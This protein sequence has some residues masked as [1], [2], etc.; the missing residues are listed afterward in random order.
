MAHFLDI[1]PG[2][3]K[4]KEKVYKLSDFIFTAIATPMALMVTLVFW[5]IYLIDREL[6]FPKVIDLVMPP[7]INHS[8]HTMNT[9]LALGD[10][11]LVS[12]K[13]PS[14]TH[15]AGGLLCYLIPYAFCLFGTYWQTGIWLYPFLSKLTW[16]MRIVAA[17]LTFVGALLVFGLTKLVSYFMWGSYSAAPVSKKSQKHKRK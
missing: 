7:W 13:Y 14:W 16:T 15:A 1:V 3:Q 11:Y 10:M 4:V 17:L 12:H 2:C 5:S 6:I 8:I 9:L